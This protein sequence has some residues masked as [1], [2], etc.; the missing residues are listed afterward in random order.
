MIENLLS[1]FSYDMWVALAILAGLLA[2]AFAKGRKDPRS[3][4]APTPREQR[5]TT[6]R[7]R[8]ENPQSQ[9]DSSS[10][11]KPRAVQKGSTDE[12][13]SSRTSSPQESPVTPTSHALKVLTQ[14]FHPASR[15]NS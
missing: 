3:K 13:T 11:K 2:W 10:R 6:Q 1:K 8:D 15:L 5:E 9:T 7:P 12:F 14:I 4:K